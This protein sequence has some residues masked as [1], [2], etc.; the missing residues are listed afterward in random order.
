M[1]IRRGPAGSLTRKPPEQERFETPSDGESVVDLIYSWL[2][3]E[4]GWIPGFARIR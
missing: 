3:E 1:V 4:R 2:P